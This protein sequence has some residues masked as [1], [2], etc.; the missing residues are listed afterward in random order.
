MNTVV[1]QAIAT[2]LPVITTNHSGL[3]E[4]VIN[5]RNGLVVP[6]A[7]PEALAEAITRMIEHPE[8][9]P[10]YGRFG[11]YVAETK[12]DSRKLT[13]LQLEY[14]ARLAARPSGAA[15]QRDI[16]RI[17][18]DCWQ[19]APPD[20]PSALHS[21]FTDEA[22]R[23]IGAS[24]SQ[25]DR[26]LLET[27]CGTGRFC[28]LLAARLPSSVVVGVD[29]SDPALAVAT[30]IGAL[31]GSENLVF[32]R[33]N[34]F[35]LPF[36]ESSFDI[37]FSEG[38]IQHFSSEASPTYVDALREMVRVT[39]VGGK[40]IVS[41]VNWYCWPHTL[42]KWYLSW[43]NKPYEYGYEKSFRAGELVKL[44]EDTGL[45]HIEL[46]GYYASYGF[47]RLAIRFGLPRLFRVLGRV[48]DMFDRGWISRRFGFEL[49]IKGEKSAA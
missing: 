29:I 45:R 25:S 21:R 44:F 20:A 16:T 22:L 12:Y 9:W 46:S 24:I 11:R 34:L 1:S 8:L 2:G 33:A 30:Q 40:V 26:M 5:G 32:S 43:R 35:Q 49:V 27:G 39:K 23:A 31:V 42:Y 48:T 19:L 10:T 7:D 38:V 17:W 41:V 15:K 47:Y 4:Q 18:S 14:Y 28:A 36:A 37:V 13:P 6:E 3:P